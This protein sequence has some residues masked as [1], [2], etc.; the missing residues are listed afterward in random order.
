MREELIDGAEEALGLIEGDGALAA[1]IG[2]QIG[3]EKSGGDALAGNIADDQAETV[4]AEVKKVVI[5][6]SHGACREAVTRVVEPVDRRANLRKKAALDFVGDFEFLRGAAFDFEFCGG[7]ATLGFEGVSDFVEADQGENVAVN[8]AEAR[9][10]AAPDGGFLAEQ[11]RLDGAADRAG[12]GGIELDAAEARSVI[13]ADAAARPL[14]IFRDHI[15]GDEDDLRGTADELVLDRIWLGG[16]EGKNGGAVGRSDGDEAFPGLKLDVIGE[17]EAELVEVEAEAA[18]E[19]TDEDLGGMDTQ[20]RG[21]IR[22]WCGGGH[23]GDYTAGAAMWHLGTRR[24]Y[25]GLVQPLIV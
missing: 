9:G 20:V 11:R 17:V 19:I 15:F 12:V 24:N 10:D 23:E 13:E 18:V 21:G 25:L 3:H 2:L 1:E 7:G 8:V 4:G 6:A 14:F 16:N 22:G 5:V